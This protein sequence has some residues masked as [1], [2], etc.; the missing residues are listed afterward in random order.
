MTP[1]LGMQVGWFLPGEDAAFALPI[2]I[3]PAALNIYLL[4]RRASA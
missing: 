1:P 2:G 3:A 4:T